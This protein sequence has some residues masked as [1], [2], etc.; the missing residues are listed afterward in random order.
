ML[1][2]GF[3]SNI[4][5][6]K[7]KVRVQFAEDDLLSFWL[8]VLQQKTKN[9][10]FYVL[11]DKGEHVACL[12]D[13]NCEDGVVLGA[14]YSDVDVPPLTISEKMIIKIEDTVLFE[15]D[16]STQTL[17]IKCPNIIIQASILQNGVFLNTLGIT[18]GCD[19]TD[20]VGTMQKIRE[21]CEIRHR[22]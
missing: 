17:T 1:K 11:P 14:I 13:D 5:K 2:F 22:T 15:F 6:T 21:D 20:S 8:P 9:D 4:D 3:V 7:A 16:K 19:I 18:S 10:K 12:M